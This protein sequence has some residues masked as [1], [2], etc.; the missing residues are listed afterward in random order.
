MYID[1]MA[2]L[3]FAAKKLLGKPNSIIKE[4]SNLHGRISEINTFQHIYFSKLGSQ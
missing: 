1:E 3:Q 2:N 4:S